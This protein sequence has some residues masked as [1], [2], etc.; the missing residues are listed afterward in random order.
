M[1]TRGRRAYLAGVI[2]LLLMGG[3]GIILNYFSKGLAYAE[4]DAKA[5]AVNR[6]VV[7]ANT[8]FSLKLLKELMIEQKTKNIF[9][10]P[11]SISIALAMTYNGA[12][13]STSEAM[14]ETLG[15]EGMSTDEVN[16]GYQQLL[17]S[18]F[19]AD[20]QVS[21]SLG[22]SVWIRESF[23]SGVK[24]VF[25]DELKKSYQSEVYSRSFEPSTVNEV[26]SWVEKET[27][28]KISK[29]LDEIEPE[30]VMFLINAI[31]FKGNWVDKFDESA[32]SSSDF[33][34]S[35]G[36]KEAVDMMHNDSKYSYYTDN[37][38]EIARLPYGRDKIAMYVFLPHKGVDL[39]S[40]LSNLEL[41]T[42]ENYFT[43]LSKTELDLKL[44]KLKLEYGKVDLK[45]ALTNLGMG[46]A[47]DKYRA[48]L[49]GIADVKPENLYI[50]FVDHKAVI[51]V[52][53]KGTE[54]AAVTNVGISITSMPMRTS[55]T[56][57]RP[58]MFLIRDDRS[59]SILFIGSI[60]N[61]MQQTSP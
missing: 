25:T 60:E 30:N 2:L 42:L 21:L 11:L 1:K 46:I 47:F 20:N 40:F 6:S 32:T 49:S 53:E 43:K 26:N 38:V 10:S 24:Q 52:N 9:I 54:A 59:G 33:T 51:E 57:D 13:T 4:S 48:D 12:N 55:F 29:I 36:T 58:Y 16:L 34:T 18:L 37:E 14:A 3:T 23:A 61:P 27:N 31:Y 35:E 28:G 45:E 22:N 7:N 5:Q 19:N 44:P 15:F 17:L 8:D 39:D 50:A 56:V 41:N